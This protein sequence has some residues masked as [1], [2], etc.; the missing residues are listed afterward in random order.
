MTDDEIKSYYAMIE[1]IITRPTDINKA[2]LDMLYRS[3]VN[4]G[5]V[6]GT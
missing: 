4:W 1:P 5:G 6:P 3:S 2:C